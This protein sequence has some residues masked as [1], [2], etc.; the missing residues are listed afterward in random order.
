MTSFAGEAVVRD[1]RRTLVAVVLAAVLVAAGV[2]GS[3]RA[4]SASDDH[5]TSHVSA[6]TIRQTD[7]G[8]GTLS[9]TYAE[10]LVGLGHAEL[11]GLNHG[12]QFLVGPTEARVDVTLVLT[13]RTKA[14]ITFEP[15]RL[16][17]RGPGGKVYR[18]QHATTQGAQIPPGASLETRAGFVAPRAVST[19]D[20][21]YVEPTGRPSKLSLG[22]VPAVQGSGNGEGASHADAGKGEH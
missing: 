9:V 22:T 2:V 10:R 6:D 1:A 19:F 21:E 16:R 12:V 3:M 4:V 20:L 11:A 15:E 8:F 17:L 14:P 7:T 5:G 13:N 18:A